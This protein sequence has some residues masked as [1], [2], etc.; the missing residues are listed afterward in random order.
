MGRN[1]KFWIENF[2]G[3][4]PSNNRRY[5]NDIFQFL[6]IALKQKDFLI[7]S[8]QDTLTPFPF[9]DVFIDFSQ[10]IL[11]TSTYH[12]STYSGLLPHKMSN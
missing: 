2:Q 10:N 3:T 12:K 1:E 7:I 4:P 11:K 9:L 6:I 5:V 8:I